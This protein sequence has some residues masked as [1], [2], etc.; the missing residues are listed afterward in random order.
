M[1]R[2]KAGYTTQDGTRVP[3]VTTIVGR[4]KDSG[5]LI[6][7]AWDQGR[8]G[9]DYRQTRDS[10][11]DAGTLAHEWVEQALHG[12]I[13][14]P[15]GD[16][17]TEIERMAWKGMEAFLMWQKL[18]RLEVIATEE[19]MVSEIHSFGGTID[20]VM[21]DEEKRVYLGDWKTGRVYPD[22]LLQM[23][24]YRLLLRECMGL[25]VQGVHLCR[26]GK[27]HGDFAHHFIPSAMLAKPERMFLLLREAYE[28]DRDVRKML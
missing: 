13:L 20:A 15:L 5:G 9:L 17:A 12:E 4:F 6:Y 22:H 19:S 14:A 26:F 16:E 25:E 8:Q 27:E 24:A 28:L 3:G 23:A 21:Q 7:W 18:S 2:P 11:A 10:A 1:A